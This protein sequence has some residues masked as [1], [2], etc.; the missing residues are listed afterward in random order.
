MTKWL[1][2]IAVAISLIAVLIS[3]L[4]LGWN[5]KSELARWKAKLEVRQINDYFIGGE[6]ERPRIN[7][8]FRNLSHRPTAV[9]EAVMR[10]AEGNIRKIGATEEVEFPIRIAPWDVHIARFKVPK[11]EEA[12]MTE[13]CIKDLDDKEIVIKKG[14]RTMWHD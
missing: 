14:T 5:V 1:P 11:D 9:L 2:V 6:D 7:L 8:I 13:L 4:S 10:G 3:V 12:R